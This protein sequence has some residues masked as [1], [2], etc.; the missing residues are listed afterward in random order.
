MC[1][2]PW[3]HSL[4][5][6][7]AWARIST[8]TREELERV[9]LTREMAE[10]WRDFYRYESARNPRSPSAAG[11]AELMQRAVELLTSTRQLDQVSALMSCAS[12][13]PKRERTPWAVGW[14]VLLS[15]TTLLQIQPEK[16]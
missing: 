13:Y 14:H 16:R 12:R 7:Q 11:R 10:A 5:G 1:H 2:V 8:L 9:G 4:C 6:G 3:A 15:P